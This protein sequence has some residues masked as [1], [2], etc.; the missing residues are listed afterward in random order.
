[1]TDF[2]HRQSAHCESGVMSSLLTH[3][4]LPMSEP[5]AFGLGAALAF[6]AGFFL[7]IS[8]SDLLP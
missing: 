5:M 3:N 2:L 1:M 8:L 6:A 4:G 7:C